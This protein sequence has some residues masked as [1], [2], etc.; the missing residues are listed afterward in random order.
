MYGEIFRK[1]SAKRSKRLCKDIHG[2]SLN[3]YLKKIL[4]KKKNIFMKDFF[5]ELSAGIFK[6]IPEEMNP[7]KMFQRNP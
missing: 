5:S 7:W 4:G 2:E 6:A 1:K 3:E